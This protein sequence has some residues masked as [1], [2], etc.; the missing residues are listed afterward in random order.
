MTI[1]PFN[2]VLQTHQY[3]LSKEEIAANKVKPPS[4]L[5]PGLV[6]Q[7]EAHTNANEQEWATVESEEQRNS[8]INWDEAGSQS[9]STDKP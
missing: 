1:A 8:Q 4:T 7:E 5:A 6:A 3:L 2:T 9:D